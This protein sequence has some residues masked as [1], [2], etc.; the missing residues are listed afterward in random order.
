MATIYCE[1]VSGKII[2]SGSTFSMLL[3][4]Q[5]NAFCAIRNMQPEGHS[6]NAPYV[7]RKCLC[8]LNTSSKVAPGNF[9]HAPAHSEPSAHLHRTTSP[10]ASDTRRKIERKMKPDEQ[11][12]VS[13]HTQ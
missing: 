7:Y 3:H 13:D 12:P 10:S 8:I 11:E 2:E 1:I 5:N 9:L 4:L 6:R